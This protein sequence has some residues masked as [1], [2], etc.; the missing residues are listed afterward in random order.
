MGK[1]MIENAFIG[2]A[3]TSPVRSACEMAIVFGTC[4]P[5]TMCR[6]VMMPNAKAM[7]IE[8]AM[9]SAHSPAGATIATSGS[10]SCSNA[11]SPTH[12]RASD[13]SVMPTCEA[14][15]HASR[16]PCIAL[17]NV[18]PGRRCSINASSWVLRSFTS[19]NSMATKKP[20]ATT[21]DSARIR[22][23]NCIPC[24]SA[25]FLERGQPAQ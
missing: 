6:K 16:L 14:E 25:E 2:Q 22:E 1:A 24:P 18:A 11:G 8:C 21:S 4:S 12:P 13:A 5:T 7:P 19:A 10:I 9:R 20:F 15:S 23:P 3:S 17:S